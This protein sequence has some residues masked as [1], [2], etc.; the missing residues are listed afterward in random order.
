MKVKLQ[1]TEVFQKNWKEYQEKKHRVVINEGGTGSSKTY[2]LAQLMIMILLKERNPQTTIVR[3]TFPALRA[4]AMKDFFNILKGMG[5]YKEEWHNKSEYIYKWPRTNSE[6][7]FLS[8]DE[9]MR[10]RSRRRHYLWLNE[11]NEFNEEDFQQLNMRTE[12]QIFLDYNPSNQFHW[13]YDKL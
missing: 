13:I 1:A 2:S 12:R 11:S 6:V 9:P 10:V 5:G 7:D 8:I 3:N 4:T